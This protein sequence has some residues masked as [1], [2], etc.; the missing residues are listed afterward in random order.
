VIWA[1]NIISSGGCKIALPVELNN[2]CLFNANFIL[3]YL[4]YPSTWHHQALL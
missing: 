3:N 4:L 2:N 1:E